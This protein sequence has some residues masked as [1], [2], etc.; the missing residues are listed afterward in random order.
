MLKSAS[1]QPHKPYGGLPSNTVGVFFISTIHAETFPP[2]FDLTTSAAQLG[3][4]YLQEDMSKSKKKGS[5]H[6]PQESAL[7]EWIK[8][9]NA[10]FFGIGNQ[11]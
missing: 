7:L 8:E 9:S 2:S 4:G 6:Q 10:S 1:R 11:Y 5:L 3:G